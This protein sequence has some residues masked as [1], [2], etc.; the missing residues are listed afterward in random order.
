MAFAALAQLRMDYTTSEQQIQY[1]IDNDWGVGGGAD[2]GI[3]R[4]NAA[5][6]V[7]IEYGMYLS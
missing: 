7:W 3:H 4:A 1:N 2:G 5:A 6:G